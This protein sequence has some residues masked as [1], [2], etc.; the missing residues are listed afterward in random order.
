MLITIV[1][2]A[3]RKRLRNESEAT[4]KRFA[5]KIQTPTPDFGATARKFYKK[6]R[7]KP[8]KAQP[9]SPFALFAYQNRIFSLRV[10]H[11]LYTTY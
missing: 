8:L 1:A 9:N 3:V 6:H 2:E 7:E 10:L 4:G 5:A 11:P